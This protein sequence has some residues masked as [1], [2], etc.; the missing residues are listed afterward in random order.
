MVAMPDLEVCLAVCSRPLGQQQ[1][2]P[3][4]RTSRDDNA[5]HKV[6]DCWQ[7]VGAVYWQCRTVA[8]RGRPSMMESCT[9]DAGEQLYT[10]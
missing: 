10:A 7:I 3:D 2:R 5:V 8:C 6:G 9:G 4:G 1:R